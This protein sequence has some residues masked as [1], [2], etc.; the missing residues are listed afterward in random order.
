MES[1]I[2]V[3]NRQR[4]LTTNPAQAPWS[5]VAMVQVHTPG[6]R[7][8]VH[9]FCA[10]TMSTPD[11]PPPKSRQAIEAQ[12]RSVDVLPEPDVSRETARKGDPPSPSYCP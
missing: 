6:C 11:G 9:L 12:T 1:A 7:E 3:R 5:R 2:G 10:N 8:Q 4:G